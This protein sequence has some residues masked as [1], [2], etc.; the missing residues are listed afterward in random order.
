MKRKLL[1]E[2]MFPGLTLN[3]RVRSTQQGFSLLELLVA[4][5]MLTVVVIGISLVPAM[6]LGRQTDSQTYAVNLAREV[7]DSYRAEW[8]DRTAFRNGTAPT[9]PTNLRFSCT[10]AA[11][12]VVA[13]E[14]NSTYALVIT[15]NPPTIRKVTV[16]VTCP[17]GSSS[18]STFMGDPTP[19][20]L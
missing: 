10:I 11:P 5:T 3:T 19:A 6:T 8:L 7:I 9:L 14:L 20:E 2:S 15:T 1:P 17:K 13:Y 18:L 4:I 16:S 12:T